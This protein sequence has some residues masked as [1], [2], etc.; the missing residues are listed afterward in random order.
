MTFDQLLNKKIQIDE[1]GAK[2]SVRDIYSTFNPTV[3]YQKFIESGHAEAIVRMMEP[4]IV[5]PDEHAPSSVAFW[6]KRGMVKEFHWESVPM[7]WEKYAARTGYTYNRAK[8]QLEQDEWKKWVSYV[9]VSAFRQENR[10]KKYPL[11]FVLHGGTNLVHTV[12][13]WGYIDAAAEKEWIVIVPT[14]EI[15][16]VILEILEEAKRLYPVDESRIYASGFSYGGAMSCRLGQQHPEVFAAVG[17]CGY[18]LGNGV[19]YREGAEPEPPFDGI[20]R[21]KAM[22][23]YMPVISIY[24]DKDGNRY[25]FFALGDGSSFGDSFD[26][27]IDGINLWA[28]VND[29][30]PID[31]AATRAL[32][33]R[34]D[35]YPAEQVIG[36]PLIPEC[37]RQSQAD[38]ITYTVADLK[39]KDGVVR[40]R[41]VCEEN[42]PHWPTPE[43]SRLVMDFCG[44]FSR[45][46]ET[47]ESIYT[48]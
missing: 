13:G 46:P 34:H 16:E 48:A 1:N 22:H 40:V 23:T 21:A 47:K 42:T 8:Y 43:M 2:S 30:A 27:V 35:L 20:P 29:A 39:S 15:D 26:A 36:I 37:G 12:E 24:G 25:P 18:W 28:E 7:D 41:L 4:A 45:D 33:G 44:H 9:P 11:M 17:P 5:E 3:D 31:K 38:G 10:M 6:A 32:A 14:L 19:F